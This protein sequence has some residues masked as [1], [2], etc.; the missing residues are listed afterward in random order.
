[1]TICGVI[2]DQPC[3]LHEGVHDGWPHKLHACCLQR[4]ADGLSLW[5]PA[6]MQQVQ[7][8]QTVVPDVVI[9]AHCAAYFD[10]GS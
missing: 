5:R 2:I 3:C 9:S 8:Q 6:G 10:S 4:L 7:Q 1:M